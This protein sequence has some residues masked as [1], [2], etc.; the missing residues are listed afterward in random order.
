MV[1]NE[2]KQA[3]TQFLIESISARTSVPL[4]GS[5]DFSAMHLT[6]DLRLDSLDIVALFFD[7]ED[8]FGVSILEADVIVNGLYQVD[9]LTRFVL[10]R[11]DEAEA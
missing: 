2:R 6:D 9:A 3:L 4:S 10:D 7:I 5:N 11:L 1:T 8:Q